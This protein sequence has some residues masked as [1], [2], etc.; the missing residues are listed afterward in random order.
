MKII[1]K[2]IIDHPLTGKEAPIYQVLHDLAAQENCDG[3]PYD[4]MVQA[5]ESIKI[6]LKQAEEQDTKIRKL[7]IALKS[8]HQP[9]MDYVPEL[10]T[11]VT[12]LLKEMEK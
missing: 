5:A 12:E 10:D 9:H 11:T 2:A 4:Q 1:H 6:L 8:Q 7:I 3:E